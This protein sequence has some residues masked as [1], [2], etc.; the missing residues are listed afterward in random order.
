[1]LGDLPVSN[2]KGCHNCPRGTTP[3]NGK[4]FIAKVWLLPWN[5]WDN[6]CCPFSNLKVKIKNLA[7]T[8]F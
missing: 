4:R 3:T 6:K 2:G 5:I 8:F 1:M 7:L